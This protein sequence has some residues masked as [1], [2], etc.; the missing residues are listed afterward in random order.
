M[1]ELIKSKYLP[2]GLHGSEGAAVSGKN[3]DS[4]RTGIVRA[5]WPKKL[6]MANPYAELN[7]LA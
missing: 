1:I 4:F 3:V 7:L 6:P 2:P 5:C